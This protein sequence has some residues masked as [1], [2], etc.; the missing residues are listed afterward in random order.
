VVDDYCDPEQAVA[1]ANKLVDAGVAFVV[2][3][4]CSGA[5]IAASRVYAAAGILM[6][7]SDATN[8]KL[9]EQGFRNVFR[10]VGRDDEQGRMAGDYL[11]DHW[12]D[13]RIAIVH[14]GQVY[15][16]GL[17]EETKKRLNERGVTEAL[18]AAITPGMNDYSQLVDRLKSA[19]IDILYY[20]GYA[21]EAA[22]I[23]RET[24]DAGSAVQLFGGDA[25]M[26]QSFGQITGPAGEGTLLT[27]ELEYRTNPQLVS[28]MKKYR[29]ATDSLDSHGYAAIQVWAQAAERARTFQLESMIS[30]LRHDQF[31]T[32]MGRIGFDAKGD[33]TGIAPFGF[34]VW[35]A[36]E[37]VPTDTAK[38]PTQ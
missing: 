33:L 26:T 8:P 21:V 27:S 11:A 17:A 20:G 29:V 2:G 36:G 19:G 1:A 24:R 34:Y 16:K 3:H 30:V 4:P 38:T 28:D 31:D 15:G 32:V 18:F 5:A 35:K 9:T 7:T 12:S 23:L 22:L 10:V 25:I 14:D 37:F 6:L 13:K